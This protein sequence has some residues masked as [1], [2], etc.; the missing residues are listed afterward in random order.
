MGGWACCDLADLAT[1]CEALLDQIVVL[2]RQRG[3]CLRRKSALNREATF[4]AG[5]S[6]GQL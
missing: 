6:A 1:G 3:C 2:P 4:P 5:A